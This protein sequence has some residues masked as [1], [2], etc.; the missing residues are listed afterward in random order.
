MRHKLNHI[1]FLAVLFVWLFVSSCQQANENTTG[2][3]FMPDMAHSIAYEANTYAYYYNNTWGTKD[4]YYKFAQ[5]GLPVNGTIPR[6]SAGLTGGS[7]DMDRMMSFEG[8]LTNAG[9]SIPVN[10]SVPYAY[11]DTDEGRAQAAAEIIQNPI[12]IQDAKMKEAKELYNIYCGICHGEK[13]D[14]AGYLVRDDGKYPAQPANLLLDEYIS[15]SNGQ[16]YHA[17]VHGKNLMGGYADKL[18]FDERWNVIHYIRSLQAKEKKL[19]YNEEENTLNN[20]ATP[21]KFAAM[22]LS[23]SFNKQMKANK[24]ERMS[25]YMDSDHGHGHDDL[26]GD[27]GHGDDGHGDDHGDH[28]HGD[29][30][31]GDDHGDHGHD[32]DHGDHGND[33]DHGDHDH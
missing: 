13:G 20:G 25:S 33:D 23:D 18:S 14:G 21:G 28:G 27:H 2:S 1:L 24:K 26:H 22:T 32:D 6:G 19:A 9:I 5:P 3:E 8:E 11:P 31:H 16:Y 17:I 10:G 29:E 12:P 7:A 4:E 30:G 15:L